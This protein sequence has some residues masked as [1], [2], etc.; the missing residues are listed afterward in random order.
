MTQIDTNVFSICT[1]SYIPTNLIFKCYRYL[2]ENILIVLYLQN[3]RAS[4]LWHIHT[5]HGDL[6]DGISWSV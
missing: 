1:V 5:H 2:L 6:I 3:K 4:L